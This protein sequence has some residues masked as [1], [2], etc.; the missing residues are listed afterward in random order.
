MPFGA[1]QLASSPPPC[2]T[3]WTAADPSHDRPCALM[4]IINC[5]PDSFSDGGEADEPRAACDRAQALIQSGA[6]W[7]DLGAESTRPGAQAITVAEELDRLLP[8]LETIRQTLP[9]V[10]L[11]V[12]TRRG[13]VARAALAA[14]ARMINDVGGGRDP[15]LLAAVAEADAGLV[16]MHMQGEP[17][18]MQKAPHYA[19]VV[20]EVGDFLARQVAVAV[21]AGVRPEAILVD[22]GIGFGKTLAHNVALLAGLATIRKTVAR[23]L[24]V[25]VSRKSL[26]PALLGVPQDRLQRDHL[27]HIT[28]ALLA[29]QVALLRVHDVAGA[30]AALTLARAVAYGD[31]P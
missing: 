2:L 23:P 8:V 31:M 22:P 11:S 13:S 6:Q 9:M 30:S 17:A 25:G 27:S 28:H 19:D 12:D 7:L 1:S 14:G 20:A 24:L 21:A 4:G 3:A 5:T 16:L 29:S 18:H 15:D 26:F 10:P